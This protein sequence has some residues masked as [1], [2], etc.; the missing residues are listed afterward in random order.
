MGRFS[1]ANAPVTEAGTFPTPQPQPRPFSSSS[2]VLCPSD[3]TSHRNAQPPLTPTAFQSKKGSTSTASITNEVEDYV[4]QAA[5]T[6]AMTHT[7]TPIQRKPQGVLSEGL[8][9][10][11]V[12]ALPQKVP[13][14][15]PVRLHDGTITSQYWSAGDLPAQPSNQSLNMKPL[16]SHGLPSSAIWSALGTDCPYPSTN[17]YKP[18]PSTAPSAQSQGLS[19]MLPP[20]RVL[21][22]AKSVSRIELE[23]SET[24]NGVGEALLPTF[25]PD[26][27]NGLQPSSLVS[28]HS[29]ELETQ[30]APPKA[31]SNRAR[32]K[33]TSTRVTKKPAVPRSRKKAA[34]LVPSVEELLRRSQESGK[35][36]TSISNNIDTQ[37]LL[38]KVEE[39]QASTTKQAQAKKSGLAP[40]VAQ[41]ATVADLQDQRPVPLGSPSRMRL[42]SGLSL[43]SEPAPQARTTRS[44]PEVSDSQGNSHGRSQAVPLSSQDPPP[45]SLNAASDAQ[46]IRPALSEQLQNTVPTLCG[47]SIQ[48]LNNPLPGPLASLLQG[49]G[50]AGSPDLVQWA[51]ESEEE[52]RASLETFIC[53]SL[54]DENFY[55]LC[56]DLE[57]TWQRVFLGKMV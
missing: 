12:Y 10:K 1:E 31:K 56:K 17:L 23:A 24:T 14:A 50:F 32:A 28:S 36:V 2:S 37:A 43:S 18:R 9:Q 13:E 5:S 47:P 41:A 35:V 15:S 11:D 44:V 46:P 34:S 22:F 52:R 25:T 57:G 49:P 38:A 4:L 48:H 39:L 51:K 8:D 27:D 19:E 21:P 7:S 20:K 53:R 26:E 40:N 3:L 54:Q 33:K 42:R 45:D 16:A 6:S 30:S 55:Q 29:L